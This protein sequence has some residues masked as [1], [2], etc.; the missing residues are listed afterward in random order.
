MEKEYLRFPFNIPFMKNTSI[1]L[2]GILLIDKVEKE[3]DVFSKLFSGI[4][5]RTKDF[6]GCVKL[7]VYNKVTHSVSI[8]QIL[9]TYPQEIAPHFGMK[10]MPAERSLYRT[11][12]RIGRHFPILLDRYQNLIEEHGLADPNQV[13]DFSSTYLEGSKAELA[14]QGYSRDHRPDRLQINFGIATGINTIPTALTIQRGNVQDK[15]HLKAMLKVISK[16]IPEGS[17][18]IFDT[19]ANTRKNKNRIRRIRYHYLT[20]KA[21]HVIAYRKPIH[22]FMENLREGGV[23]CFEINGRDY[24][25]VKRND[26]GETLYIFFSPKLYR[27]QI[28]IKKRKFERQKKKGNKMLGKRKTDKLPS[29]K[30][31][32]ELIPQL[33]KTLSE[34]DNVYIN[35]TE[36]F[37]ILESSVDTEPEKILHLYKERDKA[38]KFIRA[39][40]EGIELRPIR[41]WSKNAII[42]IFFISFLTNLLI[43]LTLFLRRKVLSGKLKNVKLLKKFLI[44]LTVTIVYPK[45]RFRFTVLSNVSPPI[46]DIFGDFV[47]KYR[48]KSLDLRW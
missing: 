3:F 19:G 33:Q 9:Q 13:I 30:G 11:P 31:W 1:P 48:D 40:K 20:L 26:N 6:S 29:D 39:L 47:W 16:V 45:N 17:L 34:L 32:V 25:C 37:F 4:G 35:G 24:Y 22:Y 10:E 5:G 41:H 44:N 21:K 43:N 14:E 18:L 38:E 36:G 42:G 2:G 15:K 27:T 8:N 12:E 46:L 28:A 7:L 23:E